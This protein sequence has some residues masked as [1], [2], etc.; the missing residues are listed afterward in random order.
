MLVKFVYLTRKSYLNKE[1]HIYQLR[2][3]DGSFG[4]TYRFDNLFFSRIFSWLARPEQEICLIVG[5]Y[6][7]GYNPPVLWEI[8][9]EEDF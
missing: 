9:W 2:R 4:I 1:F 6:P 5:A 7:K 3:K 8:D